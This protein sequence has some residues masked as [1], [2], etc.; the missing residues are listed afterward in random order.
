VPDG[1]VDVL[2]RDDFERNSVK[3]GYPDEVKN[4]AENALE[5]VLGL[6]DRGEFPFN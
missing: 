5:H 1:R 2:D 6:I 3:Y 4:E